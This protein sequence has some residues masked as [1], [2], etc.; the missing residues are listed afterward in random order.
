[1]HFW[2]ILTWI[3]N[4]HLP[5]MSFYLL[6]GD[7]FMQQNSTFSIANFTTCTPLYT[8]QPVLKIKLKKCTFSWYQSHLSECVGFRDIGLQSWVKIGISLLITVRFDRKK[9][10]SKNYQIS[11]QLHAMYIL[12]PLCASYKFWP[13]IYLTTCTQLPIRGIKMRD[14][15]NLGS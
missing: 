3:C 15:I 8:N 10:Q 2:L 4:A 14:P 13:L 9:I 5:S 1:M 6:Q 12:S 11:L 7:V